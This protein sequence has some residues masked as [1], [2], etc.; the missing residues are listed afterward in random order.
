MKKI[1]KILRNQAVDSTDQNLIDTLRKEVETE[2]LKDRKNRKF[3]NHLLSHISS[4]QGNR[5]EKGNKYFQPKWIFIFGCTCMMVLWALLP[6]PSKL[7]L[8]FPGERDKLD[9]QMLVLDEIKETQNE[10]EE[11]LQGLAAN[12]NQTST[13][14]FKREWAE[15]FPGYL[16]LLSVADLK[17][18]F[19]QVSPLDILPKT[20]NIDFEFL[21][22]KELNLIREIFFKKDTES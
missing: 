6:P 20:Q 15:N 8:L 14:H 12:L 9:K 1:L 10:I 18:E 7:K 22:Q 3:D 17:K 2:R 21:Y 19:L 5:P 11:V 4:I 16:A 13:F